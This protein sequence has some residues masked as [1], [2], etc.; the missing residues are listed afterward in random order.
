VLC[1]A[2][3]TAEPI[4]PASPARSLVS[5][6]K[7]LLGVDLSCT[8]AAEAWHAFPFPCLCWGEGAKKSHVLNSRAQFAIVRVL[9]LQD[10]WEDILGQVNGL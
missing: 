5:S 6:V 7:L 4:V 1:G 2:I 8:G 10:C 3:L 9:V